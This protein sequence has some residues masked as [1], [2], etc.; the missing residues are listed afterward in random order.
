MANLPIEQVKQLYYEDRLSCFEVAE[1]IG[2]S[3]NVVLK[4]M[5]KHGL[6]RRNFYRP[7]A[8]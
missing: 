8:K 6:P 7:I 1:K 4:F 2:V 5:I 3:Q